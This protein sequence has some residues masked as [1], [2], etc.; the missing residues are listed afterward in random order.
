MN[1][2]YTH[3][4]ETKKLM[5][6][7]AKLRPVRTGEDAPNYGKKRTEESKKKT[8]ESMASKWLIKFP[9]GHEEVIV[10]LRNFCTENNL[11]AASMVD[12]S[13]GRSESYKGYT[14][15]KLQ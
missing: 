15:K 2:G 10:S 5:S 7:K 3:S 14:C 8:S 1:K 4:E 11:R 12:V 6:E 13:K 9:D